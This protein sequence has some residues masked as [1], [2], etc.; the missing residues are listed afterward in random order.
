[1][2]R[3][4]ALLSMHHGVQKWAVMWIWSLRFWLGS[5][6]G[7]GYGTRAAALPVCALSILSS[8]FLFLIY[9]LLSSHFLLKGDVVA[10]VEM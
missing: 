1:M 8:L 3:D 5:V 4:T 10:L 6:Y 2:G 9:F 7:L